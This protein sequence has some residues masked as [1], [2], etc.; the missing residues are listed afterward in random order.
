MRHRRHS[1]QFKRQVVESIV[2]GRQ[3][4]AQVCRE[5]NLSKTLVRTWRQ[6]YQARGPAAFVPVEEAERERRSLQEQVA[7]LEGALG[8][9]TLESDFLK[10]ALRRA[11]LPFPS[12]VRS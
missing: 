2:N 8:R 5:H 6:E 10:R 11:G 1:A 9:A 4:M 3:S 7:A 12:D